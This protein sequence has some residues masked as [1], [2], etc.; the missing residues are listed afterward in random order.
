MIQRHGT[1]KILSSA[2]VANGVAYLSGITPKD[3]SAGV[4]AQTLDVLAQIDATLASLGIDK[5]RIVN[6]N[7]WLRDI[8]TFAEMNE[9]WLEWVDPANLPARATV[10]AKMARDDILVEIMVQ[11]IV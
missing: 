1:S 3:R 8:G 6:A 5:T 11:A 2:V 7:I 4:K 10:E 9:G